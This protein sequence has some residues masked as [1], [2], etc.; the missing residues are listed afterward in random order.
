MKTSFAKLKEL[1]FTIKKDSF[2]SKEAYIET[3]NGYFAI[4]KDG[5]DDFKLTVDC[6]HIGRPLNTINQVKSILLNL[7]DYKIK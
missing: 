1:G 2:N 3:K 7:F 5:N 6:W 4:S